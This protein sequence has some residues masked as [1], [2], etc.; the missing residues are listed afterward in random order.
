MI[1]RFKNVIRKRYSKRKNGP[2]GEASS[3]RQQKLSLL[4]GCSITLT[5]TI[6]ITGHFLY[7]Y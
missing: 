2:A 1:F 7:G 4:S 5:F 6:T 3:C